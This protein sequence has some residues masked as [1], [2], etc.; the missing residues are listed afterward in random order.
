MARLGTTIVWSSWMWVW[1]MPSGPKIRLW[2]KRRIDC[3]LTRFTMIESRK[4]P[5]LLY[6]HSLPGLKLS[7]RCRARMSRASWSVVQFSVGF[8]ASTSSVV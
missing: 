4:K 2:A 1:V 7:P 5:E 6:C 8:P 3:P